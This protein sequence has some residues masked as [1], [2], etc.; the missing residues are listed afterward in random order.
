MMTFHAFII[1]KVCYWLQLPTA[2]AVIFTS[3][4]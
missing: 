4:H 2:Q 3:F 1:N